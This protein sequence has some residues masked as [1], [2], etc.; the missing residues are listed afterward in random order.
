MI[1]SALQW[2]PKFACIYL[3]MVQRATWAHK[4]LVHFGLLPLLPTI[5]F[6]ITVISCPHLPLSLA[7]V[8][9]HLLPLSGKWLCRMRSKWV[10]EILTGLLLLESSRSW[11]STREIT[12]GSYLRAIRARYLVHGPI[13]L[14][15]NYST[16]SMYCTLMHS[17]CTALCSYGAMHSHYE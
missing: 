2:S 10:G 9:H 17:Y 4:L 3:A 8:C 5:A 6:L 7:L 15:D 13:C 11:G 14:W 16:Y 12:R 1:L